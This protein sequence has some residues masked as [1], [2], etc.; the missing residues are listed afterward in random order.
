MDETN[1]FW[2]SSHRLESYRR[3]LASV[4]RTVLCFDGD[5]GERMDSL[6]F[7]LGL[8]WN[9]GDNVDRGAVDDANGCA[10][11]SDMIVI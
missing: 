11:S 7:S 4:L 2:G 9:A 3:C 10:A 1:L 8:D 5:V 6:D